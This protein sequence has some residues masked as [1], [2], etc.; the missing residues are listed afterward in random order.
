MEGGSV[1]LSSLIDGVTS[2]LSSVPSG[3][4]DIGT[5]VIGVLAVIYGFK[6]IKSMVR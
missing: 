5:V 2:A 3:I 6:L 1:D 4:M